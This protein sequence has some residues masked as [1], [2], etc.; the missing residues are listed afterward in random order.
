MK[1]PATNLTA[2][3]IEIAAQKLID[4]AQ[5]ALEAAAGSAADCLE[6]T[7]CADVYEDGS[8]DV[9]IYGLRDG[10]VWLE[11]DSDS[12]RD[13]VRQRVLDGDLETA[14]QMIRTIL[15]GNADVEG[16]QAGDLPAPVRIYASL[17]E[18]RDGIAGGYLPD[19]E[20][21]E[22]LPEGIQSAALRRAT[23]NAR[24]AVEACSGDEDWSEWR[25]VVRDQG[26]AEIADY[27]L[28]GLLEPQAA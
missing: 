26:G 28:E 13:S 22:V 2:A 8:I 25:V 17:Y 10:L 20:G 9:E 4:Q 1:T 5:N 15:D 21:E 16:A 23:E 6:P 14:R 24:E 11:T 18:D 19:S 7:L 12:E 3:Q 27:D